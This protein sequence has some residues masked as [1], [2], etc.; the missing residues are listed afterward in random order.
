MQPPVLPERPTLLALRYRPA[1]FLD[2]EERAVGV[3]ARARAVAF[4]A[5]L[6]ST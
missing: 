3:V 2:F 1:L 5:R 4:D 6:A